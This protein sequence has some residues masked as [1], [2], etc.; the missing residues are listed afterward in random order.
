[1]NLKAFLK[2][3]PAILGTMVHVTLVLSIHAPL[4]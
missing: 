4:Y 3:L 2:N 1:M